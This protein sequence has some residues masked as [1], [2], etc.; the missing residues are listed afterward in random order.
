MLLSNL[1]NYDIFKHKNLKINIKF[2]VK[3]LSLLQFN[4]FWNNTFKLSTMSFFKSH[5]EHSQQENPEFLESELILNPDGSVYHLNLKPENIADTILT[6]GDPSRVFQVS[7]HFEKI[8]FEMVRREF[9]THTGLYKGKRIS[10]MSTGM[11]TDNIEIFMN[12]LDALVNIDLEKRKRKE[13]HTS[14][15]IIRIGTSGSLQESVPLGSHLVTNYALGL[16]TLMF[17]YCLQMD[18]FENDIAEKAQNQLQIPFKPYCVKGSET[19]QAQYAFDM[20]SGNTITCPGF[21]APQGRKLRFELQYPDLVSRMA[22]FRSEG[23]M[24][25]NF[26]METAGYYSLARILGHEALSL[27]A[28]IANRIT[29]EFAKDPKKVIDNLVEKVLERVVM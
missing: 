1:N 2:E 23:L 8:E 13:E 19:L 20:I 27:N 28:I 21:Y 7:E 25:T 17:F 14:L 4:V 10:V 15:K 12:E 16:D 11:G 24:F 29:H 18:D 5:K 6:V 9:I 3:R 26:E 22:S